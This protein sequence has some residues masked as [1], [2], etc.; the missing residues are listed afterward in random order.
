[1]KHKF[2]K[3]LLCSVAVFSSFTIL[4]HSIEVKAASVEQPV[5]TNQVKEPDI[6]Y[7]PA[8]RLAKDGYVFVLSPKAIV[9]PECPNSSKY[10]VQP[11][12]KDWVE[13]MAEKKTKFKITEFGLGKVEIMG[14]LVDQSGKQQGWISLV[15]GNFYHVD[16]KKKALKKLIKAE[17]KAMDQK[18]DG[19]KVS[20]K[21]AEA[22]AK[23]LHGHNRKIALK[24]IKELKAWL[25]YDGDYPY[26]YLPA[27]TIDK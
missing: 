14:H 2:L 25:N 27:L 20:L 3:N 12:N 22:E 13:K 19:K 15:N 18:S 7:V 9:Y 11:Y 17:T 8:G 26:T 6:T 21:Q 24:S 23:K 10:D 4:G 16:A 1:M 5:E